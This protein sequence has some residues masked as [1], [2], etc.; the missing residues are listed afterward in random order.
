MASAA[1]VPSVPGEELALGTSPVSL[2]C[3]RGSCLCLQAWCAAPL[4][5]ASLALASSHPHPHAPL[6]LQ[7]ELP[8][9]EGWL[10]LLFAEGK[11]QTVL[12]SFFCVFPSSGTVFQLEQEK[13]RALARSCIHT[14]PVLLWGNPSWLGWGWQEQHQPL[15]FSL[16]DVR[17]DWQELL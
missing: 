4:C 10:G 9:S 5:T 11:C 17:K 14:R 1:L 12:W 15:A 13:R 2:V 16:R 3:C 7:P 6:S 8:F